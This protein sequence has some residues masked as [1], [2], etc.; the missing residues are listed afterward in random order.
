[1]V[2]VG[3]ICYHSF[4]FA[5]LRISLMVYSFGEICSCRTTSSSI[6]LDPK[7]PVWEWQEIGWRGSR[8][9][10]TSYV[11]PKNVGFYPESVGNLC[12]T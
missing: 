11:L 1:M 10:R 4:L 3:V 12:R 9:S 8:K 6:L 2:L 7:M 5:R